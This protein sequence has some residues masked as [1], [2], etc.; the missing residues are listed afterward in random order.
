MNRQGIIQSIRIIDKYGGKGEV[1]GGGHYVAAEC[2]TRMSGV[3]YEQA[4]DIFSE[5]IR[6][7][8][9]ADKISDTVK[10]AELG[11]EYLVKERT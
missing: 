7:M 4:F 11:M 8:E 3:T 10:A 1:S 2:R 9:D 5:L 6:E